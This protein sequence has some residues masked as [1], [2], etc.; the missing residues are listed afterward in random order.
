[1]AKP[2]RRNLLFETLPITPDRPLRIG[3]L[4][5][6]KITPT[7]LINPSKGLPEVEIRAIA[8]RDPERAQRFAHR[9]SIPVVHSS[10]E[11]IADDPEIDALYNPLPNSLHAPWT[12]RALK[13]GKH[14]L[15][16]KPLASNVDEARTMQETAIQERRLLME[17]FHWRYHPLADRVL[18]ILQSGSLGALEHIE[19]AFCVPLLSP[20]NIRYRLDLAGG[21]TMDL[22]AYTVNMIRT[23]GGC[24]PSVVA[25][26]VKQ[27]APGIDRWLQA[28][29][30][31]GSQ[32][33]ARMT[34]S[35][36]SKDL[37]RVSCRV[38][39]ENGSISIFNPILP[40][41]YHR[42]TLRG[43]AGRSIERVSGESTYRCQLRAFVRALQSG[44]SPL[45]DGQAGV[46][47]MAVID[48]I[49]RKAGLTPRGQSDSESL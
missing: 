44:Q 4:G 18:E 26:N 13:A 2:R 17:A 6:A 23:F 45:T 33:T 40:Q 20:R 31:L 25:A 37:I 28:E 48:D 27:A 38:Q 1:M 24:E 9:Y 19:T 43:P 34:V 11:A 21:A 30:S 41:L 8:A 36:F 15:C 7:A 29:F 32:A 47:N 39:C 35:F 3:V 22:G 10:Y 5:A 12:I 46:A 16:E 14:V 42:L 49:Y